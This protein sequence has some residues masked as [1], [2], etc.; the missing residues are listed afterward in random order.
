MI[1]HQHWLEAQQEEK[2]WWNTCANT[3]WEEHKQFT[4]AKYMGLQFFED[5]QSPYNIDLQGKRVVDIGGGPSSLL[6]KAKNGAPKVSEVIDPCR[7]PRWVQSRYAEQDIVLTKKTG[8]NFTDNFIT[9]S[10]A[11]EVWIYNVLQHT[12]NPATIVENA[13]K[14]LEENGTFRIFE[15]I[16]TPTNSAHPHSLTK[17]KLDEWVGQQGQTTHLA[18]EGCYGEAYYGIFKAKI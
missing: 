14:I 4:Y 9:Y 11:D 18:S 2:D 10:K 1:D 17:E 12:E 7:Y 16:N 8:E 13:L 5:H 3:Y 15:W 6:L